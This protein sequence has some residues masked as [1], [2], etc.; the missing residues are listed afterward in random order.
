[1]ARAQKLSQNPFGFDG[2]FRAL[3]QLSAEALPEFYEF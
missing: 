2:V 3:V 1:V